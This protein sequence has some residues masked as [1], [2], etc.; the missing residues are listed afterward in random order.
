MQETL[1]RPKQTKQASLTYGSASISI[2]WTVFLSWQTEW[3]AVGR[4]EQKG[5]MQQMLRAVIPLRPLRHRQWHPYI[6]H[7]LSGPGGAQ[8]IG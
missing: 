4:K 7:L 8:Y 6:R 5:D 2:Y 3:Q 1:V